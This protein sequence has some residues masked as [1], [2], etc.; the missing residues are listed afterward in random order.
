MMFLRFALEER[1]RGPTRPDRLRLQRLQQTGRGC[2]VRSATLSGMPRGVSPVAGPGFATALQ[3]RRRSGEAALL[4]SAGLNP[5]DAYVSIY[6][7][8]RC[9]L[10]PAA[11]ATGSPG[12]LARQDYWF[13]RFSS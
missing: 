10:T 5:V 12:L 2:R 13:P 9:V 3:G 1:L 7:S 4:F 11:Y 6:L 8:R